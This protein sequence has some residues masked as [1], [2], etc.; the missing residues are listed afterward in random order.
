MIICSA[1]YYPAS[2][3]QPT[4]LVRDNRFYPGK[5]SDSFAV[6]WTYVRKHYPN[7]HVILFADTASPTPIRP[8]LDRY[9]TEPYDESNPECSRDFSHDSDGPLV[10]VRW[11][12]AHSGKYFWPMQRNLVEAL[13]MG[14][15]MEEDMLWIDSDCFVDSN[16]RSFILDAD[17][18]SSSVEHYQQTCGSFCWY[19]SSK[20]LHALDDLGIDLPTYLTTMLNEGSTDTR[21][22]SLQEGGLYKLFW[23]GDTRAMTHI[24]MSHL[25]CYDHFMKFLRA[26]PLETPEYQA[27]VQSL[28][29]I[30]MKLLDGVQMRFHDAF[31]TTKD[32]VITEFA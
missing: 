21:M 20:R 9:L 31:H 10:H 13:L 14:Y 19:V 8:L 23:Y 25:S 1:L 17:Y 15:F 32:G 2:L 12:S 3:S 5:C 4:K 29:H 7:E 11:L 27:L 30:N 26:N 6:W 24:E 22:H 16:L 28:D 18:A